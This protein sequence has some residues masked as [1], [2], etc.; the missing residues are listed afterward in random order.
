MNVKSLTK[1][2]I[3]VSFA[4]IISY[5]ERMLPP[6]VPVPGVKLGLS[7]LVILISLYLLT[8]KEAFKIM[9]IKVVIVGVL[10]SGLS[11][12]IYGLAGSLL[13][14]LFMY[15]FKKSNLFSIVGV[16][17]IGGV[18]HNIGQIIIASLVIN[19][20]KLLYYTPY[21][22]LFGTASGIITGFACYYVYIRLKKILLI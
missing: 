7:N 8:T 19:N 6:I 22:I 20:A 3:L 15:I 5:F 21:L 18:M 11:G 12:L 1:V 14:F 17:I 13:S 4:L 10:F 2:G 16:S 9:I